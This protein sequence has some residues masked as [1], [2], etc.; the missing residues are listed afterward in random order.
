MSLMSIGNK[1]SI[2]RTFKT[3]LERCLENKLINNEWIYPLIYEHDAYAFPYRAAT[4]IRAKLEPYIYTSSKQPDQLQPKELQAANDNNAK[5]IV[6]I[7][8]MANDD[9]G[10]ISRILDIFKNQSYG[11][12]NQ[13]SQNWVKSNLAV[14]IALN[15][16]RSLDDTINEA[17]MNQIENLKKINGIAYRVFGFFWTFSWIS[18]NDTEVVKIDEVKKAYL[19][20]RYLD[21]IAAKEVINTFEINEKGLSYEL[22]QIVNMQKIR[23]RLLTEP[24]AQMFLDH[25]IESAPNSPKYLCSQ[26]ADVQAI[27]CS[28]DKKGLFEHYDYLIKSYM[29]KNLCLPDLLSTGYDISAQ[30]RQVLRVA[31][32]IDMAVRSMFKDFPPYLPEPNFIWRV[33]DGVKVNQFSYIG[34]KSDDRALESLRLIQNAFKMKLLK[35]RVVFASCGRVT[36]ILPRRM[37]T[38]KSESINF[39]IGSK[40]VLES[41]RSDKI[42]THAFPHLWAYQLY[43]FLSISTSNVTDIT[44]PLMEI[45]NVFNPI[46]LVFA[47]HG[48]SLSRYRPEFFYEV[49]RFYSDYV[50][51]M[52][53]TNN[54]S[55]KRYKLIKNF[56]KTHSESREKKER[57]KIFLKVQKDKMLKAISQLKAFYSDKSA[58]D[59]QELRYIVKTACNSGHAI[60]LELLKQ[61]S[62]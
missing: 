45:Y 31:I 36:T 22:K 44:T 57:L 41:L 33:K 2:D 61:I 32:K 42:Q 24:F 26:D 18:C 37:K 6:L 49:M 8:V 43:R 23:Q 7:P 39:I 3:T 15:R 46:S 5:Y 53:A 52:L 9:I 28:K 35:N 14:V 20:L 59:F 38:I 16:A 34:Q 62:L 47:W 13:E 51:Y 40:C 50:K 4:K 58:S 27:R 54:G 55:K 11:T 17:F 60:Y 29:N 19:L 10:Q 48:A 30:E 12:N 25:F 21:A 1:L 56:Y